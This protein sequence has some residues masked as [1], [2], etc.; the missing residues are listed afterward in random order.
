MESA[1]NLTPSIGLIKKS[2]RVKQRAAGYTEF[3]HQ[4]TN[5]N[6]EFLGGIS[7]TRPSPKNY[8]IVPESTLTGSGASPARYR[9]KISSAL[10]ARVAPSTK[11]I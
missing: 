7:C 5:F 1:S 4:N 9:L 2:I 8:I 11:H 3:F 10:V 6:S